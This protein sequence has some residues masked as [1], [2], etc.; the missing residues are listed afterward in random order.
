MLYALALLV[1]FVPI[2]LGSA[3]LP[4]A[5]Q[6]NRDQ[7]LICIGFAF[8]LLLVDEVIRFFLRPTPWSRSLLAAAA[9]CVDPR[10]V[11]L[12]LRSRRKKRPPTTRFVARPRA[13][14]LK[15]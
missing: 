11:L 8:G 6:L 9:R 2:E 15:T 10:S 5:T 3:A 14:L 13:P 4:G 7:W 12:Q 1:I